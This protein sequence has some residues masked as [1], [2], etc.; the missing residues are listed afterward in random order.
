MRNASRF[1][2]LFG[3][4]TMLLAGC[5]RKEAPPPR[6]APVTPSRVEV[7][8]LSPADYVATASSIDLFV[9][10]ASRLAQSRAANARIRNLAE[11][12]LADHG[13]VSAQLSFAGRR[14][15]LLPSATMQPRHQ[16]ML[17]ELRAAPDFDAAWKRLMIAA[18][19]QGVRVHGDFA[20][21][22]TS[23]TLRPVAEVALPAMRRHLDA[24]RGL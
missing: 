19:D 5:A 8:P 18:H 7:L 1:L 16:T 20:R 13:G 17:D 2:I 21:A 22:G 15:N 9:I 10:E 3:L 11:T 4:G 23:P 12:L 6:P 14:L 24:L